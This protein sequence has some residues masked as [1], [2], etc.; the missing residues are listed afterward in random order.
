MQKTLTNTF[1]YFLIIITASLFFIPFLGGV[2]LFDWDEV[3]FAEIAREMIV[4]NNFLQ[5]QINYEPF[6]EKPPLFFWFQ[7]VSMKIFG[8]N[9]FAARFPNAVTGIIT[10]L[11]LYKTGSIVMDRKFGFI[12]ALAYFGSILPHF[13]FRSGIIDPMFNLF[14]YLG[15]YY[16]IKFKWKKEGQE[17]I[18]L[19]KT[20]SLYLLLGGLFIGL[21]I[22]TKGPVAYLIVFLTIIVYWIV[23]RFRMFASVPQFVL[24]SLYAGFIMLVWFSIE[25]LNNGPDFI[26][27]FIVY[28]IRLLN[29]QDA[30][31]AGF[32]GYH[33]VVLLIGCFPASIFAIRAFYRMKLSSEH[34]RDFRL[35]MMILFWVVLGLFT[36]VSTKIVHYSSMAYFPLTFMGALTIYQILE[37]KIKINNWMKG[38][39]LFISMALGLFVMVV[40]YL[41]QHIDL[42]RPMYEGNANGLAVLDADVN[43]TGW[44]A[45]TGIILISAMILFLVF[46]KRQQLN[47]AFYAIFFGTA[48]FIFF[49]L[50]FYIGRIEGYTQNT[51]V[52][53]CKTLEGKEARVSTSGFKSYVHLFYTKRLPSDKNEFIKEEY[54]FSKKHIEDYW[55]EKKGYTI[56]E[57]KNGYLMIKKDH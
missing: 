11:V 27:E 31:H 21:A 3:N 53:M 29:T 30:G 39:L 32:P 12:W 56:L 16:F 13:Y 5:V 33:V 48:L 22:L 45:I 41:G 36:L 57:N 42:L 49:G 46:V 24:F 26:V 34:A 35:W 25:Y 50:I 17:E 23:K 54:I 15:I 20:K 6:F 38:G 1:I 40:P 2:H 18:P 14:I 28:Q 9:E 37:N 51:Y 44:E 7:V 10:L 47:R 19:T 43:W 55:K 52:E 4:T 8:I